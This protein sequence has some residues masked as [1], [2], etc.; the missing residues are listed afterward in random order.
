MSRMDAGPK[1]R[2]RT[3]AL[4]AI[5]VFLACGI[6]WMGDGFAQSNTQADAGSTADHSKFDELQ[7]DFATGP[8]VTEACL[9]CHTEAAKQLHKTTH[10]TWAFTNELTGQE[11]G[12]RNVV[13]NFCVA[14]A[15]NW[16][17]CTSCHIGYGW[18]DESFNLA[19]ERNVDCLACH[20]TTGTYKK[21]PTGSGHPA[22]EDKKFGAKLFK[23][24]DLKKVAQNVGQPSRQTCGACHFY[25]GGG[26]GVKHGDLDA[27][28][29]KPD[30]AL[31]V[32]MD[33]AGLNFTCQECHQTGSHQ[34][35]GSRYVTRVVDREGVVIPGKSSDLKAT[36]ESCHG[37]RPHPDTANQKLNDHTDKLACTTCHVPEYAR[38]GHKTKMWWD[39]STAGLRENGK[40]VIKKDADGY[41][42][43]NFKKGDFVWEDNVVPEYRWFDGEVRY[44]LLGDPIDPADVVPINTIG[45]APNDPSSRIWPFKVMRGRQPYDTVNQVIGV[46]HLFGKDEDAFWK[47]F[48]WGK[49]LENGL[50]ARGIKF[51]G[52]YDFLS[53][54]YYWP[55]THMVAPKEESLACDACHAGN[56]RMAN[57]AGVYM[58]GRDR[59]PWLDEIG[60]ALVLLTLV[61]VLGHAALRAV[62]N[63]RRA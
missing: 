16:P 51:S 59:F 7:K 49:A 9:G 60:W 3:P 23:A 17:R 35:A 30:K 33:A 38:G 21:F 52:E 62:M 26:N 13:N 1:S 6:L 27:S 2:S 34:V 36:C 45:G 20:D 55:I 19:S 61:G 11:L 50:M 18:K 10:W 46:P 54:E 15:T 42:T 43:Y 41:D 28:L 58:S 22:Y 32:H 12:K 53:T 57:I 5:I 63:N 8:E 56:G 39:W 29:G 48:D 31:D 47:S 40:G 25:G 24:V 4:R 44:T 37:M 14:T